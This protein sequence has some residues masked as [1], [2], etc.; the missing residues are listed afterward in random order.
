MFLFLLLDRLIKYY[1]F[2]AQ[3]KLV[4]CVVSMFS[5]FSSPFI[6]DYSPEAVARLGIQSGVG[7]YNY[8]NSC[9]KKFNINEH[10][11]FQ[12]SQKFI[13]NILLHIKKQEIY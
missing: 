2:S 11:R 12:L 6:L 13:T 5:I 8:I 1:T 9:K 3:M 7:K 4:V 10:Q